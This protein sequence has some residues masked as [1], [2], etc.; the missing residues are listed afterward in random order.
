MPASTT[1]APASDATLG[2]S[3]SSSAPSTTPPTTS[4]VAIRLTYV[5]GTRR[6]AALYSVCPVPS[7]P[8]P[9]PRI[10]PPAASE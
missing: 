4:S 9:S 5:A 6:S 7:G 3:P 8:T 1:D 10:A 2:S